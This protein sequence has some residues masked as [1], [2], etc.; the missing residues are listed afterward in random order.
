M[1]VLG[2]LGGLFLVLFLVFIAILAFLAPLFL[3]R[4]HINV[5]EIKQLLESNLA[6]KNKK[7]AKQ[8]TITN[9]DKNEEKSRRSWL[10]P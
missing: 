5:K 9:A 3:W 8:P 4:I 6:S 10:N 7:R 2:A 1:E